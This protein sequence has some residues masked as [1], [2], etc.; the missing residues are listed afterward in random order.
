MRVSNVKYEW[1]RP[2]FVNFKKHNCPVCKRKLDK[3]KISKIVN[4]KSDEAKDFDFFLAGGDGFMFGN[5]KFIRTVFHCPQCDR[6]YSVDE[7]YT[8][9]KMLNKERIKTD[10]VLSGCFSVE[11]AA[12]PL[13]WR[14]LCSVKILL[15]AHKVNLPLIFA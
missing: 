8:I 7:I 3:N 5:V 15:C 1:H 13:D 11:R 2:F 9:K 6:T 14:P 10:Y 4:S 12:S